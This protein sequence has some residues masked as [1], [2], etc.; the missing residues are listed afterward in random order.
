MSNFN[1]TKKSFGNKKIY[2]AINGKII[3]FVSQSY[4]MLSVTIGKQLLQEFQDIMMKFKTK[5]PVFKKF[6]AT[7]HSNP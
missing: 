2:T 4:K 6:I 3:S 5:R 7:K 1:W